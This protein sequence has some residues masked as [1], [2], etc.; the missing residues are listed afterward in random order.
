MGTIFSGLRIKETIHQ[1]TCA[2][3]QNV[4]DKYVEQ[5]L[6][7]ISAEQNITTKECLDEM[8]LFVH[9]ILCY[10]R[11]QL[12][13]KPVSEELCLSREDKRVLSFYKENLMEVTDENDQRHSQPPLPWKDGYPVDV[14]QSLPIAMRRLRLQSSKLRNNQM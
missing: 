6:N 3:H 9:E 14:S 7:I 12:V 11:D 4:R 8:P 10:F 5:V 1:C 13:L 2:T